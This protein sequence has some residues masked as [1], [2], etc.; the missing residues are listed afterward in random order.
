MFEEETVSSK[1]TAK[2]KDFT[3]PKFSSSGFVF[4]S[5][6]VFKKISQ[7]QSTVIYS[8]ILCNIV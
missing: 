7:K 8:R 5:D 4:K 6:I 2:F 1:N 3:M